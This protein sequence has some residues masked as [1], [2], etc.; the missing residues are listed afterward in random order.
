MTLRNGG[1][2]TSVDSSSPLK[3]PRRFTTLADL[4]EQLSVLC[5]IAGKTA[6]APANIRWMGHMSSTDQELASNNV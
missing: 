4:L 2:F 6:L 5:S 1:T 3:I